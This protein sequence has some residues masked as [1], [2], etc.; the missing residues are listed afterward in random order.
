M[1]SVRSVTSLR[2]S[3]SNVVTST[4]GVRSTGSPKSRTG[5]TDTELLR[6]GW[7]RVWDRAVGPGPRVG[8]HA[9]ATTDSA[10]APPAGIGAT[11]GRPTGRLHACRSRCAAG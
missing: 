5:W 4:A 7:D 10:T 3:A 9:P 11:G 1:V 6:T 2:S 8:D